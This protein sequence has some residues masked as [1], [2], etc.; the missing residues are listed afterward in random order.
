MMD[1]K[2]RKYRITEIPLGKKNISISKYKT[3]LEELQE[4]GKV[5]EIINHSD[6]DVVDFTITITEDFVVSHETLGLIDSSYLNNMVMFDK[7]EKIRRYEN[8]EEIIREYYD[9]RYDFYKIRKNGLIKNMEKELTF[10]R[11]KINF[12]ECVLNNKIILKDKSTEELEEELIKRKFDKID[13]S[14]EY[15]LSIQIRHMTAEKMNEL[16]EKEKKLTKIYTEYKNKKIEKIWEE[17]LDELLEKYV[18]WD[19][20]KKVS[21]K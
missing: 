16:K 15:L 14:Y 17:E 10:L 19:C 3:I 2:K 7:N 1:E 11:N 4:A 13:D 21:K 20:D 8:V 18:K 6:S 12:L 9:I 5:K